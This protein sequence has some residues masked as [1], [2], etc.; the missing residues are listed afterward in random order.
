[1]PFSILINYIELNNIFNSFPKSD[2]NIEVLLFKFQ[3]NIGNESFCPP[4]SIK[5]INK[6]NKKN[7][8]PSNV[9]FNKRIY[10]ETDYST[11]PTFSTLLIKINHLIY[12][13]RNKLISSNIIQWVNFK[14]FDHNKNLMTGK[15]KLNLYSKEFNDFSYFVFVDNIIEENSSKIYFEIEFFI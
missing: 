15:H 5:W 13:D 4:I 10:F 6:R 2:K 11:L 8:N 3:I 9:L 12:D 14:L 1:M 7:K